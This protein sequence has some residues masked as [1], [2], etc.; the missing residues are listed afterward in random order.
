MLTTLLSHAKCLECDSLS[1]RIE[2]GEKHIG[3]VHDI[4]LRCEYCETI[5]LDGLKKKTSSSRFVDLGPHA[6]SYD[7]NE[8]VAW[9][10]LSMGKGFAGVEEFANTLNMKSFTAQTFC[11]LSESIHKKC[12]DVLGTTLATTRQKVHEAH[13][14]LPGN[15]DIPND[16]TI[17]ITVSYD[18]TWL[19]R[20]RTSKHGV[21]CVI[22]TLTGYVVD[23]EVMSRYC[24]VCELK[25]RELK[26]DSEEFAVFWEGH[27]SECKI[28]H[29]ASSGAMEPE[30]AVAMLATIRGVWNAIHNCFIRWRLQDFATLECIASVW[31]RC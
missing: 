17:D 1:L 21:G 13:R 5:G 18:G 4:T 31:S 9:A 2:L 10:F 29:T 8:R 11:E 27:N 12:L 19:T 30:A 15:L 26:E 25:K 14:S 16:S 28:N 24:H 23:A 7:V 22:D 3:F 6:R 20:G